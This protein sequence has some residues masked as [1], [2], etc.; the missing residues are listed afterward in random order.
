MRALQLVNQLWV[1]VTINPRKNHASSELY[2]GLIR[3]PLA[4][5]SWFTNSS[6]VLPPTSRMVYQLLVNSQLR[7][8]HF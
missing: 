2:T 3:K 4:R 5:G 1:I 6:R 7:L 8:L